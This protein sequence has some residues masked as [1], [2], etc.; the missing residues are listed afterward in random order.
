MQ[1]HELPELSQRLSQLADA[2]GARA[3]SSAGLL[4]WLDTLAE[5]AMADLLAVLTDWPK[6]HGKMPLPNEVLKLCRD[7]ATERAERES[8]GYKLDGGKALAGVYRHDDGSCTPEVARAH[9]AE[10][11][12]TLADCTPG[13]IAGAFV[14]IGGRNGMDPLEWARVLRVRDE[15]GEPLLPIQREFA[16]DALA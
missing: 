8:D 14:H 16:R 4:V 15:A 2:L 6:S 5:V 1:K 9:L 12:A 11:R 13:T 10:I 3:P 7:R